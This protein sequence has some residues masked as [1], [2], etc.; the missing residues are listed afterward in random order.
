[1]IINNLGTL[2]EI[3]DIKLVYV[4]L[5]GRFL[6]TSSCLKLPYYIPNVNGGVFSEPELGGSTVFFSTV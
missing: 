3:F 4:L 1:M 5:F 2:P 6:K